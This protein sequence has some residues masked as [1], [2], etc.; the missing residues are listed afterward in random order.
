MVDL[1]RLAFETE[2]PGVI[3]VWDP[4]SDGVLWE[5]KEVAAVD[6]RV[7]EG[8]PEDVVDDVSRFRLYPDE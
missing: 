5:V 4:V 7:L 8:P 6:V 1:S 3:G 2:P